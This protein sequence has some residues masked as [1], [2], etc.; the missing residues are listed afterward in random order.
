MTK[1]NEGLFDGMLGT[2]TLGHIDADTFWE[3]LHDQHFTDD[4]ANLT[5]IHVTD[6]CDADKTAE[7][8]DACPNAQAVDNFYDIF[9]KYEEEA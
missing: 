7:L 5:N 4:D 1:Y 6:W 2:F 8:I 9:G 3:L